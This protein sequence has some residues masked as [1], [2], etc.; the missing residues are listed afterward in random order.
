MPK[1]PRPDKSQIKAKAEEAFKKT[2]QKYKH[3]SAS[4][5]ELKLLN[6]LQRKG[7]ISDKVS[8]LMMKIQKSYIPD[9]YCDFVSID[10]LMNMT[11]KKNNH[12]SFAALEGLKE[13]FIENLLPNKPLQY[14]NDIEVT[15]VPGG[16]SKLHLEDKL[17]HKY[18]EFISILKAHSLD[19]IDF[20]KKTA[21]Q[22]LGFL[23]KK[24]EMQDYIIECIINKLGDPNSTIPTSVVLECNHLVWK[25]KL[26]LEPLLKNLSRFLTR[27]ILL[28]SAKFYSIVLLNSL[29]LTIADQVPL[30]ILIQTLLR[31][32]PIV[33][34]ETKISGNK[35][36]SLLLKALNKNFPLFTNKSA[37]QSF[38]KEEIDE[39]YKLAHMSNTNIQ[40]E[41]LRFIFQSEFAQG[42]VSD[43]YYRALYEFILPA[44]TLRSITYKSQALL[45]NT[46]M[47]SIKEDTNISRV[48]AFVKRILQVCLISEP[49]FILASFMLLSE[50]FK[51]HKSIG[52]MLDVPSEDEEEA[53]EDMPDSDEEEVIKDDERKNIKKIEKTE[54]KTEKN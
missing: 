12:Q 14:I 44:L 17:K 7:T 24:P 53:Y 19:T 41:S 52:Q 21:I 45:F 46:L 10:L 13:L 4:D 30:Q 9:K 38:F 16:L 33:L 28:P 31:L 43:R 26:L 35:A 29:K 39:I 54:E 1:R 47:I 2:E 50:I 3:Q 48:K 22:I 25:N 6:D 5:R 42:F 11:K 20:H 36:V 37:Y 27:A 40:I 15:K 18:T 49:P 8:A 51:I 32:F 34:K 23:L